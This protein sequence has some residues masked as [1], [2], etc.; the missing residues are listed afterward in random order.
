M[1]PEEAKKIVQGTKQKENYLLFEFAYNTKFVV[2]HKA[3]VTIME[4]ISQME[5]LLDGYSDEPRLLAMKPEDIV[6]RPFS[7]KEYELFKMAG[8]LNLDRDQLKELSQAK[9]T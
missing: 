9:E 2:P 7:H 6:V 8:L 4:A 3:G 1:T 5:K